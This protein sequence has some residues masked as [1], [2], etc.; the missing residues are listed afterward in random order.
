MIMK[1]APRCG[2]GVGVHLLLPYFHVKGCC[3]ARP[4]MSA[5]LEVVGLI[6]DPQ[7]GVSGVLPIWVL[8][9]CSK[10]SLAVSRNEM[11]LIWVLEELGSVTFA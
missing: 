6:P 8:P 11:D 7:T 5:N 9:H 1:R 3:N 10:S 4:Q 2:F